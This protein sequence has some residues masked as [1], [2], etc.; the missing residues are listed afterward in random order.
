[1]TTDLTIS[2]RVT[3]MH[4]VADR[5]AVAV[6]GHAKADTAVRATRSDL[7]R[8]PTNRAPSPGLQFVGRPELALEW[9][10]LRRC[11]QPGAVVNGRRA[12]GRD[13]NIVI[14]VAA[15]GIT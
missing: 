4:A 2:E 14:D 3:E 13:T 11:P 9:T 8:W 7:L 6:A 1:M 5:D 12:R 15:G 10:R